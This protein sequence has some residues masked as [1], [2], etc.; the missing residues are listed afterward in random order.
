MLVRMFVLAECTAESTV[1][2][3][4]ES[5][6]VGMIDEVSAVFGWDKPRAIGRERT[7]A[8]HGEMGGVV[9]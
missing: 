9:E 1:R 5:R 7:S 4:V 6:L 3:D 2:R 8:E